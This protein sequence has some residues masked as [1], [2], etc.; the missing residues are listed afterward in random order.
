MKKILE[1]ASSPTGTS[2]TNGEITWVASILPITA[3]F[4]A[5]IHIYSVDKYGRKIGLIL[6]FLTQTVSLFLNNSILA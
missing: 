3:I 6:I 1:S 5:P 2:L 4:S